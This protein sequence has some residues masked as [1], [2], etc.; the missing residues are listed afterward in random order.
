[1]FGGAS[2][3]SSQPSKARPTAQQPSSSSS[4]FPAQ[5]PAFSGGIRGP[6][7]PKDV[8]MDP[9]EVAQIHFAIY[10]GQMVRRF[11]EAYPTCPHANKLVLGLRVMFP[12]LPQEIDR[13]NQSELQFQFNP[14]Q[15]KRIQIWMQEFKNAMETEITIQEKKYPISIFFQRK[16]PRAW[17]VIGKR[18]QLLADLKIPE[19]WARMP[20][21]DQKAMWQYVMLLFRQTKKVAAVVHMEKLVPPSVQQKF[22]SLAESQGVNPGFGMSHE[23]T[24]RLMAS[25]NTPEMSGV[26]QSIFSSPGTLNKTLQSVGDMA[27]GMGGQMSQMANVMQGFMQQMPKPSQ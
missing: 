3:A 22:Q 7:L 10:A 26:V 15:R 14:T 20:A 8:D 23:E 1:M 4:A 2:L 5:P 6:D 16:D 24:Q 11:A 12:T 13:N 27:G 25:M 9:R 21:T 19:R 18:V 17:Q